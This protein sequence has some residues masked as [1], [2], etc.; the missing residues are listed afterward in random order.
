MWLHTEGQI[1]GWGDRLDHCKFYGFQSLLV[2][3]STWKARF[4]VLQC[5]PSPSD[6]LLKFPLACWSYHSLTFICKVELQPKKCKHTNVQVS[7]QYLVILNMEEYLI[8]A[9]ILKGAVTVLQLCPFLHCKFLHFTF[10]CP[11]H[12]WIS[13]FRVNFYENQWANS[14]NC[15]AIS[16][17]LLEGNL[18]SPTER[19]VHMHARREWAYSCLGA[20]RNLPWRSNQ[21]FE[22]C[23]TKLL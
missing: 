7:R 15:K 1:C 6:N 4:K 18:Y 9:C 16:V 17:Y 19:Q 2:C 10:C 12:S 3:S 13:F 21:Q 14:A 8:I 5:S 11:E 23:L 20:F 22:D